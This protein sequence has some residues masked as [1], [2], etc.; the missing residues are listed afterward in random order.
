M[1]KNFT[2]VFALISTACASWQTQ[3]LEH[4]AGAVEQA[5]AKGEH[6]VRVELKSGT[7][8]E[9]YGARVVGDSIIGR[10]T[11]S[12]KSESER[13]A[14]ATS[15]VKS[16]SRHKLSTGRTVLAVVAIMLFSLWFGG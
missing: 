3:H 12:A 6:S 7:R 8:Y 9:I 5:G 14:V 15:D 4:P 10:T 16:V 2:A 1:R 13:I 11:R